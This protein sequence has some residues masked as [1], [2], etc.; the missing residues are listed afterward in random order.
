MWLKNRRRLLGTSFSDARGER[1]LLVDVVAMEE[2]LSVF[3]VPRPSRADGL[4][5]FEVVFFSI[6]VRTSSI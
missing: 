6:G 4:Q 5:N 2:E 3:L 1:A